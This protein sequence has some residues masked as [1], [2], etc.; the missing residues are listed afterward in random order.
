[1]KVKFLQI[2]RVMSAALLVLLLNLA[3]TTNAKAQN[4]VPTGAINGLFSVSENSQ[5]YFSQGNL[6][7]QA[8][9]HTW[10]FAENQWDYVG[11]NELGTVY[12]KD[13]NAIIH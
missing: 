7:Y 13:V 3:G 11:N 2:K 6:Q 12:E 4:N 8:S 9:T 1:M 10:R 5:V